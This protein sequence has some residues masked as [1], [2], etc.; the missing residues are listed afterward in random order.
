MNA[1]AIF[2]ENKTLLN[3]LFDIIQIKNIKEKFISFNFYRYGKL[4]KSKVQYNPKKYFFEHLYDAYS[5]FLLT[6]SL[7]KNFR[8]DLNF[9]ENDMIQDLTGMYCIENQLS[10]FTDKFDLINK[11][12]DCIYKENNLVFLSNDEN[13]DEIYQSI[14]QI[15]GIYEL[16]DEYFEKINS[17]NSDKSDVFYFN[18]NSNMN[19]NYKSE[20]IDE[21]HKF[22]SY[23]FGEEKEINNINILSGNIIFN[24]KRKNV[25]FKIRLINQSS[26]LHNDIKSQ[27]LLDKNRPDLNKL[28]YQDRDNCNF[29]WLSMKII[30]IFTIIIFTYFLCNFIIKIK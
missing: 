3:R 13:G 15:L 2:L 8:D 5:R 28:F 10:S 19:N 21:L 22:S 25:L 16:N 27:V 30:Y 23:R 18:M 24:N 1:F 9:T 14:Y 6:K 29:T 11:I 12:Y 7:N 17:L 26:F 20:G 4:L